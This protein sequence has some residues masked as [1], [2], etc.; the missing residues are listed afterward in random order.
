M[1]CSKKKKCTITRGLNRCNHILQDK[2]LFDIWTHCWLLL[3]ST[4]LKILHYFLTKNISHPC[5]HL[6][7]FI[8]SRLITPLCK[9]N[10]SNDW[11]PFLIFKT[12]ANW[13]VFGF[14]F[15]LHQFQKPIKLGLKN[16]VS[17]LYTSNRFAR[18]ALNGIFSNIY[19][20]SITAPSYCVTGKQ[21]L[22]WKIMWLTFA[23][24]FFVKLN[25]FFIIQCVSFYLC[26]IFDRFYLFHY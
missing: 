18:K 8:N 2:K 14:T 25:A 23:M 12:Q 26:L 10:L 11:F 3:H 1:I 19:S 24:N 9:L 20:Q 5:S 13:I 16:S 15:A 6:I 17:L 7:F 4:T 21:Q 22:H